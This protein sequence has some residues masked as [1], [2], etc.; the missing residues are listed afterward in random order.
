MLFR[1]VNA[2]VDI[3]PAAVK[4]NNQGKMVINDSDHAIS[5][6]AF[7]NSSTGAI[8]DVNLRG[9]IWSNFTNGAAGLIFMDPYIMYIPGGLRNPCANPVNNVCPSPMTK[10][11][12]FR[13]AM[14][15]TQVLMGQ[16]GNLLAMT[17]Q[18]GLS[19]TGQVLA[20]N[21]ATGFEFVVYSKAAS[22]FTVNL[23]GQA[24]RLV[25][26]EWLDPTTGTLTQGSA[27]N[28][29]NA[30]QTFTAPWGNAHDAVLHLTDGG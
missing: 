7:V 15:Y 11:D 2:G 22:S 26:V 8:D 19:S 20:N 28:G 3:W 27:V 30:S 21:S 24:G 13:G 14:G 6:A 12:P 18:P 17:P 29:G 23:S 1:S 9:Y 10:Y 5:S 16:L 25:N 4:T